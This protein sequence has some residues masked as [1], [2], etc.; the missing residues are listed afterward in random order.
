MA[1]TRSDVAKA[2]R[3]SPAVVSYVLNGGP[4]GVAEETRMRV[5]QAIKELNYRPNRIAS[6]LR[7]QKTMTIGLIVPDNTN[8]FFAELA[9]R[10]EDEAYV[11]GYTMLLANSSGDPKKERL[12]VHQFIDR[13]VDGLFFI[14]SSD[15]VPSID[16]ILDST[17]R[18]VILDRELESDRIPYQIL[19]NNVVGGRIATE[20][21][22]DH[23]CTRIGCIAG[24]EQM[25][26]ARA[27]VR[28]WQ[29]AID[30]GNSSAGPLVYTPISRFDARQATIALLEA[31]PQIDGLFVASDEQA[32]GVL[33][34]LRDL[35]VDCPGEIAVV[36]FDGTSYAALTTPGLSTIKQ[37]I[38]LIAKRA[39]AA[40]FD[41]EQSGAPVVEHLP[42]SLQR[43]GSCGCTDVFDDRVSISRDGDQE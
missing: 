32:I 41:T 2:A 31:D 25:S 19:S 28:G 8:P 39:L 30:E 17:A 14:P 43:R 12:H 40:M 9:K 11:H 6:S 33:R 27:R 4:R 16:E 37:P 21:L 29:Q 20:H 10:I 13:C 1:V 3:V 42:V 24:P 38:R 35:G 18:F 5:L 22:I 15:E 23:G 7:S 34:A 26:G 36:S